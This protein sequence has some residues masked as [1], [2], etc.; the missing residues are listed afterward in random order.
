MRKTI[1]TLFLFAVIIGGK[2]YANDYYWDYINALTKDDYQTAQA[3]INK[4]I[5][6]MSLQDKKLILNFTITYSYGIS[7]FN[8]L[9]LLFS[10]K[11]LPCDFD[12]FTA[13]NRNHS[14]EVIEMIIRNG[15]KPNGEILL[16]AMEKQRFDLA[17][18]FINA[19]VNVNYRYPLT[20][21]YADG[22][23]ALLYAAK[24]NNF[25]MVKLLVENGANINT[26]AADGSTAFSIAMKNDNNEICGYLAKH[27]AIVTVNNSASAP[28]NQGISG[29]GGNPAV[30]FQG[31]SF[32]L[33]G[34]ANTMKLTGN[35]NSGNVS[36]ADV[37]NSRVINGLYK[38]NGN[39]LSIITEGGTFVYKMDPN[40]SFSGYGEVWVKVGN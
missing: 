19:K 16:A 5:G 33:S 40:N 26:G 38:I 18:Q 30:N 25:E 6:S 15:A 13:I 2:L 8:I 39:N 34:S 23:T 31:G 3:I 17:K 10:N 32:R 24:Y 36:Y 20:K 37:A 29:L 35:A 28:L 1:Y 4:N 14:N 11:I 9:N 7:T 27:G 22:M 12:L 21:N